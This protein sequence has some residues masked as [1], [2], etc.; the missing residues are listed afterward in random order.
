MAN[1][2]SFTAQDD[3]TILKMRKLNQ[4]WCAIGTKLG[5]APNVVAM[6]YSRLTLADRPIKSVE[7]IYADKYSPKERAVIDAG[8]RRLAA[9]SLRDHGEVFHGICTSA[10]FGDPEPG[11]SALDRKRAGL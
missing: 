10:F 8:E 5:R 9:R 4:N 2:R 6:R 11:R 7:E 1:G 3:A